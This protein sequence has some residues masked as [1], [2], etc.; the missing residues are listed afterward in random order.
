MDQA[1][2]WRHPQ[3]ATAL[4]E[5]PSP[6]IPSPGGEAKLAQC[7]FL[8]RSDSETFH[9]LLDGLV[10]D[11]W[12]EA[13]LLQKRKDHWIL[14][15][16]GCGEVP[17]DHHIDIVLIG[18]DRGDKFWIFGL[19]VLIQ[20]MLKAAEHEAAVHVVTVDHKGV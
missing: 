14:F 6:S 12:G 2:T 9:R 11:P 13:V 1:E 7:G 15:G 4:R 18:T 17:G 19:K 8:L 20:I 3:S 5:K 10:M 16:Q